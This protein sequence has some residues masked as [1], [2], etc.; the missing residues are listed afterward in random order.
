MAN[1]QLPPHCYAC[2]GTNTFHECPYG[3][4]CSVTTAGSDWF[5]VVKSVTSYLSSNGWSWQETVWGGDDIEGGWD[6]YG[7]PCASSESWQQIQYFVNGWTNAESG[8]S[9]RPLFVDYGD[10]AYGSVTLQ[11]AASN[12]SYPGYSNWSS[13]CEWS[14]GD[15]Y[16]ASW[17]IGWDVPIPEIYNSGMANDWTH[18]TNAGSSSG[19]VYYYGAVSECS[20]SDAVQEPSCW[21]GRNNQ[22]EYGPDQALTELTNVVGHISETNET[23]I[24]WPGSK[25]STTC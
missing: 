21:V 4:S 23:N 24:Q 9:I 10:A 12:G 6:Q 13:A 25:T 5:G 16:Q 19:S 18:V 11:L 15:F 8:S 17:G 2:F 20:G 14:T 7:C 1:M 22:C 3:G